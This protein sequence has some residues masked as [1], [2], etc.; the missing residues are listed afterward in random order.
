MYV[1]MYVCTHLGMYVHISI[2]KVLDLKKNIS[3][4]LNIYVHLYTKS[5]PFGRIHK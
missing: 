5:G 3:T 4:V 2:C 1:C